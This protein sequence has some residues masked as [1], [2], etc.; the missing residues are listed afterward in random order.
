VRDAVVR[1]RP[2]PSIVA[3]VLT[4]LFPPSG[5]TLKTLP[6]AVL[7]SECVYFLSSP[8]PSFWF[9]C[10][11]THLTSSMQGVGLGFGP[12]VTKRWTE[13]NGITAVIRSHEVRQ[14]GYSVE[15]DGL[16]ITVFSAPNYV[17]LVPFPSST[18]KQC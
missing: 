13:A 7:R 1:P 6:V 10:F 16:L 8:S 12:D 18:T 2:L 5:L 15:H 14:G 11:S 17:R 3:L 9:W 4:P